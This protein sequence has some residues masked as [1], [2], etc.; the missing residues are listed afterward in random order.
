M[1]KNEL[2]FSIEDLVAGLG[3]PEISDNFSPELDFKPDEQEKTNEEVEEEDEFKDFDINK[4]LAI[5]EPDKDESKKTSEKPLSDVGLEETT[6]STDSYALAFARY[7]LERGNLTDLNEEDF[8]KIVEEQGEDEAI[9][10]L[11]QS[12]VDKNRDAIRNE[13]LDQ[14][15]DDVKDFLK[16]RDNGVEPDIAG[17]LATAKK[18]YNS[19][20]LD[21]LEDDSKE[22]L[23]NK[24]IT[25]WYKRTTKF[26]DARIKKLVE[27]HVSLGE[28]V[29][30]AKEAVGEVKNIISEQEKEVTELTKKQQK[31]FEDNHKKQLEELRTRID[32]MDEILPNYKINKQT[33]DKI[34]DMI[35]KPVAQDQY[36][37]PINAI[38]KKR[39]DDPFK[40]DTMVA[41]LDTLGIFDG[42]VD[43]LL[44]PAKN[45]AVSDLERS[46][47]SQKFGSKP[48]TGSRQDSDDLAKGLAS[49]LGIK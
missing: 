17:D 39:M 8:A 34:H 46:L 41:Y 9:S 35:V 23:R 26:N 43:K 10:W 13:I 18:F 1:A 2:E 16:L 11:F 15:E 19:L 28:D 45:S 20:N 30:I 4:Q 21:E 12:E 47:R 32:S 6:K 48:A 38:W 44:K 40:F 36:G 22:T 24:I 33:K 27:N 49:A 25:D 29:E 5:K 31:D 3:N 37:N 7:Q 14:Y 42:K